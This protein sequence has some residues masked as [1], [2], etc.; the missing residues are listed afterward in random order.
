MSGSKARFLASLD[1]E[2][3]TKREELQ[4]ELGSGRMETGVNFAKK[5]QRTSGAAM[6][7]SGGVLTGTGLLAGG[8]PGAREPK[9]LKVWHLKGGESGLGSGAVLRPSNLKHNAK[10][11]APLPRA[12]ILGFRGDMHDQFIKETHKQTGGGS[13]AEGMRQGKLASEHKIVRGMRLGR[14]AS[15]GLTAGGAALTAAGINRQHGKT[16]FGKNNDRARH[17]SAAM[18]AGGGTLA[19]V[20]QG[21]NVG[22]SRFGNKYASS[23]KQHIKE[24]QRLAPHYGGLQTTPAKHNAFGVM[25]KPARETMKPEIPNWKLEADGAH[26][27]IKGGASVKAEVGRHRGMAAQERHF[28]EVFHNTARGF[29]RVRNPALAVAGAGGVGMWASRSK[30]VTKR[31]R[32]GDVK[33]LKTTISDDDA[34]KIVGRVGLKGPLPKGL[35]REQK[36]AHYEARYVS[37]GG[38]KA[39]HWQHRANEA[40]KIRVAGV[41]GGTAAGATWLASRGKAKPFRALQRAVPHLQHKS[42][43]ALAASGV[44]VGAGELYGAHAR[45]KR[46]SYASAPA[47]V[48]ASALRRMQAYTPDH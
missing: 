27:Q 18:L 4:R 13:Y 2:Q 32:Y 15:Y 23:S 8:I 20:S 43:T 12:G 36:M 6:T 26:H 17:T 45:K 5:D 34:K 22:L 44:A 28:A 11:V 7:A 10:I 29:K 47:G 41:A 35:N 39:T 48:A 14:R 46:S 3:V 1:A 19:G 9:S 21:V 31:D 24:A 37:A 40:E 42:E 30:P 33:P 25:T 38:K 16:S